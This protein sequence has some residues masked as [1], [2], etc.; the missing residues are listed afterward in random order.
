VAGSCE[1]RSEPSRFVKGRDFRSAERLSRV[2]VLRGVFI[3]L[4]CKFSS[5]TTTKGEMKKKKIIKLM[6]PVCNIV[7]IG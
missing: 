4:Q 5:E 3:I 6:A 1:L 7:S 2:A